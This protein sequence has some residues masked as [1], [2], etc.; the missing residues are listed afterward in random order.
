MSPTLANPSG[1]P[2]GGSWGY[3]ARGV[4]AAYCYVDGPSRYSGVLS[5]R[6]LR[7]TP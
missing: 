3:L 7:R 6:L 2:R 5:L 4:R 1:A